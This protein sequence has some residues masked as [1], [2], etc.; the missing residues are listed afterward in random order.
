MMHCMP[1][2]DY[3]YEKFISAD[4]VVDEDRYQALVRAREAALTKQRTGRKP[5]WNR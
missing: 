4:G 1:C 2:C 3:T 5:R